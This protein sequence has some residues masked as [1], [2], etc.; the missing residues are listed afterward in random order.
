MDKTSNNKKYAVYA[1][2]SSEAED[3][4]MLSLPAQTKELEEI[5]SKL[6]LDIVS[7][8]EESK[9]AKSPNNRPEFSEM[10][11]AIEEGKI[12]SILVWSPDRLSRNPVDAG[13]IIY[14]MDQELLQEVRTP[15]QTFTCNPNDKFM[16]NQLMIFAKLENDNKGVNVKRGLKAKC[17]MGWYPFVAPIG[18]L[19]TPDRGK[20]YKIIVKDPERFDLM[21]KSWDLILTGMYTVP[22]V[23]DKLNNKWGLRTVKRKKIGGTPLSRSGLYDIFTNPFYYGWF[24]VKH[25]LYEGKHIPMVTKEEFDKV[26]E[27]LGRRDA[28]RPKIDGHKHSFTGMIKC[29]LCGCSITATCKIKHYPKTGNTQIYYYYHCTKKNKDVDCTQGYITKNDLE[30]QVLTTLAKIEIHPKFKVWALKYLQE[31]NKTEYGT[32]EEVMKNLQK[33]QN[34]IQEKLNR[35]LDMRLEEQLS[36]EEYETKKKSLVEAK[37]GV[38]ERIEN[39]DTKADEWVQEVEDAFDLAATAVNRFKLGDWEEKKYIFSK[40]GSN[41]LLDDGIVQYDLKK[42]YFVLKNAGEGGY[43]DFEQLEPAQSTVV[44]G[45]DG[46]EEPENPS[47]LPRV[48]SNH[49]PFA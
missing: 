15:T 12:N 5:H 47:W 18:Y 17:E 23:L 20:G 30:S 48:D 43:D 40:I 44:I 33:E 13:M 46:V 36:E 7:S 38:L 21:R 41:F 27:I 6:S 22:Q 26:Q 34:S 28:P 3:R 1:R 4:Q 25:K 14:L 11:K 49:Q 10:L 16:L 37:V 39:W 45:K 24:D 8:F 35:L 9:S 2:K 19:N 31:A 29:G 42:P 32:R